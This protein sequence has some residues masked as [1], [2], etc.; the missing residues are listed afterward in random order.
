MDDDADMA[1]TAGLASQQQQN[2]SKT[3]TEQELEEKYPH[4]P[5]NH[6][7]T[8]PFH[9]LFTTL[10][11]PLLQN[12]QKPAGPAMARK[13]QGPHGPSTLTPGEAR[14]QL[15]ERFIAR[16]RKDVGD[17]IFPA[18]RLII[19]DRDRERSMYGLKGNI[20]WS[21]NDYVELN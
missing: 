13:K 8:F 10:F 14:R 2:H 5:H 3:L 19:P 15:I 12:R 9:E 4:R 21:E 16:W 11:N 1:D 20:G 17:D 18:F 6:G 7:T